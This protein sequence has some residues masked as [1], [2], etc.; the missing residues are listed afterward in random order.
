ML[1]SFIITAIGDVWV[2]VGVSRRFTSVADGWT[3]RKRWCLKTLR[4][5]FRVF[6]G[7][8]FSRTPKCVHR[9]LPPSSPSSH[10]SYSS[11]IGRAG[12]AMPSSRRATATVLYRTTLPTRRYAVNTANAVNTSPKPAPA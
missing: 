9:F 3:C 5:P 11:P 10:V 2:G 7:K 4:K 12:T 8:N 6:D 1:Y